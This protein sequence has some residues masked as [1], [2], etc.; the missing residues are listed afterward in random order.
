[1]SSASWQGHTGAPTR[2]VLVRHGQTELSVHRRYSGRGDPPL[3]ETG[4]RQAEAAAARV[5][6]ERRVDAVVTSPLQRTRDTARAITDRIGGTATVLDAL[7][8]NNFGDWEGL[9]FTEAATR[10]PEIHRRWLGD[11]T[12]PAPGGESFADTARRVIDCAEELVERYPGGTV[13]IVSHVT[14]IKSL[15]RHALAV[16]PE[17]LFRLHLDLAS[18]SVAEFYPDGG[19]V[20]RS[21]NETAHLV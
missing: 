18:V 20:V 14:P 13:V 12:V 16:G 4:R 15:L 1:M 3:T 6:A 5:A 10:D 11:S 8:E 2:L 9:T 19:T 7:V 21:A 17:L